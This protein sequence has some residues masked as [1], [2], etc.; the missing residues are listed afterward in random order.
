MSNNIE[1]IQRL[2]EI[3]AALASDEG[4]RVGVFAEK[5]G[6]SARTIRR[7]IKTLRDLGYE[8]F[9]QT[10]PANNQVGRTT[11]HFYDRTEKLF[12]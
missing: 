2:R 11:A 7:Y 5:W 1:L 9:E 6:V 8:T 3:D 4:L 12:S 10:V